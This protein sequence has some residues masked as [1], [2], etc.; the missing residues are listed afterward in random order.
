MMA[1]VPYVSVYFG[2]ESAQKVVC[3]WKINEI[4]VS[5]TAHRHSLTVCKVVAF[6]LPRHFF[7]RFELNHISI[8]AFSI[9]QATLVMAHK[10]NKSEPATAAKAHYIIILI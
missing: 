7:H 9:I 3:S 1:S 6:F 8:F 10:S 4:W 2:N 5:L